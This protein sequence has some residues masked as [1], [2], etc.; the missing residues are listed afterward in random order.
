MGDLVV[1][2]LQISTLMSADLGW[3][4]ADAEADDFLRQRGRPGWLEAVR[5]AFSD[6]AG[7]VAVPRRMKSSYARS[8][9]HG[10][11][12]FS[13]AFQDSFMPLKF[14][15]TDGK[16]GAVGSLEWKL[17]DVRVGPTGA[18]TVRFEVELNGLNRTAS[19]A[20]IVHSYHHLK[21]VLD[22]EFVSAVEPVLRDWHRVRPADG[23]RVART[24]DLVAHIES[25]DVVDFDYTLNGHAVTPKSLYASTDLGPLKQLAGLSRM[26]RVM[27][28]YS[29]ESVRSLQTLDLGSRPDECWLVNSER[30]IRHHAEQMTDVAKQL[31]LEDVVLAA[32]LILQQRAS[33]NYVVDWVRSTRASFLDQLNGLQSLRQGQD[34]MRELLAKIAWMTDLYGDGISVS[35]DA[36]TSFFRLV[37]ESLGEAKDLKSH[38][39]QVAKSVDNLLAIA[40]AVYGERTA[41][42]SGELSELSI[43][44]T[45]SSRNAA[46]AAVVLAIAATVFSMVQ[47]GLAVAQYRKDTDQSVIIQSPT[48]TTSPTPEPTNSPTQ[49]KVG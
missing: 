32:D 40:T 28:S 48:T 27:M 34:D 35:Q 18:L 30:L 47:I 5:Q 43:A 10:R 14:S 23:I 21:P 31:F 38:R 37:S 20:E 16:S 7:D 44:L 42:A 36:G 41:A 12:T 6:V 22:D 25:Y 26:S 24:S 33:L 19:V 8:G 45:R 2:R 49:K 13:K 29:D 9:E 46:I 1:T 39:D 11:P 3:I 15:P 17:H 4:S